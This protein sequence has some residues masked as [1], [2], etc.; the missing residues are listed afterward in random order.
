V[1][2]KYVTTHRCALLS[3]FPKHAYNQ[4]FP[5]HIFKYRSNN[6]EQHIR[7]WLVWSEHCEVVFCFSCRLFFYNVSMQ[8]SSQRLTVASCGGWTEELKY[9]RLF[10]GFRLNCRFHILCIQFLCHYSVFSPILAKPYST[11]L[12]YMVVLYFFHDLEFLK[13]AFYI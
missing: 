11:V 3:S 5:E 6:G 8:G 13:Q 10:F 1:I 7:D 4:R 2:E 9:S 12:C